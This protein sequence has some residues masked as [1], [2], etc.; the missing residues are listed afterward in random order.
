MR[1]HTESPASLHIFSPAE[2]QVFGPG[3]LHVHTGLHL[4]L[5]VGGESPQTRNQLRVVPLEVRAEITMP[6]TVPGLFNPSLGLPEAVQVELPDK[7]GEVG[8]FEG[9]GVVVGEG[10]GTQHLS[11][12]EGL[13]NDYELAQ[14]V[15]T[16]GFT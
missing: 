4:G 12:E 6:H 10:G 7:A 9:V 16:D 1:I 3:S 14:W 13:V 15:P 2:P 8:G 11:L 5:D